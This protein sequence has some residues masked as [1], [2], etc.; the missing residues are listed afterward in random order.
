MYV[1]SHLLWCIT[2]RNFTW[3]TDTQSR[4]ANYA[5]AENIWWSLFIFQTLFK[6]KSDPSKSSNMHRYMSTHFET[7]KNIT[8][9]TTLR[10]SSTGTDAL[11]PRPGH[12]VH[13]MPTCFTTRESLRYPLNRRLG[14]VGC[15]AGLAS[16]EKRQFYCPCQ[17]P[18][19]VSS[20]VQ[21]IA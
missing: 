19:D 10:L 18:N 16:L 15:R 9:S 8:L 21:P 14:W 1:F 5:M 13:F 4:V 20:Q 12:A 11:N 6:N 17:E 3:E 7:S 2:L